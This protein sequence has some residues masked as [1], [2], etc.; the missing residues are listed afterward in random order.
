MPPAFVLS[1]DQTLKLASPCRYSTTSPGTARSHLTSGIDKSLIYPY[2]RCTD[3][4]AF[5]RRRLRIPSD[6]FTSFKERIFPRALP[7]GAALIGPDSGEV[8]TDSPPS[9]RNPKALR[10][11]CNNR[12][13]HPC[14]AAGAA[15]T[16]L[17]DKP[18]AKTSS[19]C[20]ALPAAGCAMSF[21]Y[22]TK[23][24]RLTLT[25]GLTA[26]RRS[27]MSGGGSARVNGSSPG[28]HGGDHGRCR[29]A[30]GRVMRLVALA[31]AI[32]AALFADAPNARAQAA[33]LAA[34]RFL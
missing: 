18:R 15:T 1:Q 30:E 32:T 4:G 19:R 2:L 6:L 31:L 28:T 7:K 23:R 8:N 25:P 20:L 11:R 12:R 14:T 34:A 24:R 17:A 3:I 33:Q 13:S 9:P 5:Q 21:I 22:H 27:A 16:P 10:R 29:L 26:Q